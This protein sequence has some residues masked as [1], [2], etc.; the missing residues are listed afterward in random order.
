V[1]PIRPGS[2]RDGSHADRRFRARVAWDDQ[3]IRSL[4]FAPGNQSR[5]LARVGTFGS[6]AVALDLEDAVATEAKGGARRL[7][8][9]VAGEMDPHGVLGVRVNP[10]GSPWFETDLQ[11]VVQ[12]DLECLVL[13]KVQDQ[14]V[15]VTMDELLCELE[16]SRGMVPGGSVVLAASAAGVKHILDGPW[17]RI[18]DLAGLD[19]AV[20]RSRRRASPGGS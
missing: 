3:P 16:E 2:V 17:T 4:L 8:A 9:E 13:P 12:P 19:L 7:V 1:T 14:M 15:L 11:A 18:D 5:R 6:D 10:P 20:Q